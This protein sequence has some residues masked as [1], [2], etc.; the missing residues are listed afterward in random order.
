MRSFVE[1]NKVWT[2]NLFLL[3]HQ[4]LKVA[5]FSRR[6]FLLN[7]IYFFLFTNFQFGNLPYGFR[8]NTWLV[9]PI[10]VDSS[11]M[12]H[13]LPVEDEKWGG[14]GGG[15]GRDDKNVH[16]PWAAEF[17]SLAKIPCKTEEERLIRDRKAFLLHNV[18]VDTVIFKAVSTI[19]SIMN[20]KDLSTSQGLN[21]HEEQIGDFN[22]VV[23]RD[24]NNAS[25]KSEDKID[26]SQLL[27]LSVKE[28]AIQNLLKG[29]TADENVAIKVRFSH[30]EH[31][32]LLHL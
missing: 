10:F 17:L 24:H 7:F 19:Q 3:W 23:R 31:C 5:L 9:P 15:Y 18:F 6:T 25:M 27:K 26:G 4:K 28:I 16:R 8:A 30:Y 1:H 13:S 20:N 14:N 11:M 29:L 12:C 2:P 21:L 22:I 32:Q